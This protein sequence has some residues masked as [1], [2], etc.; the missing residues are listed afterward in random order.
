MAGTTPGSNGHRKT[1]PTRP[2]KSRFA[3]DTADPSRTVT[4]PGTASRVITVGSYVTRPR[5][6]FD[7]TAL[8]RLS[9]FSSRG[10]T[11][12]GVRKPDL[13]APGEL[14]V[15]ARCRN[16][17]LP[18]GPDELHTLTSGTS[19]AAAQATGVAALVLAVRP[20]LVSEQVRQVL[21][22]AARRDGLTSG[23]PDD[24]W[25]AGKLDAATALATARQ[26]VFPMPADIRTDGAGGICWTTD[27]PATWT[28]RYHTVR[29]R[30]AV[31]GALGTLDGGSTPA[32]EH[33][34]DLSAVPP[35]TTCVSW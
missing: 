25:G 11:R 26:A 28:V 7:T 14:I 18:G 20:E 30:L 10:P 33:R 6:L 24:A 34:A 9:D 8:G 19:M 12:L 31:G 5:R 29:G 3:A 21:S 27:V 17:T 2:I 35:A 1:L 22:A 15:S 4:V 16:S 23:A 32:L 13:A